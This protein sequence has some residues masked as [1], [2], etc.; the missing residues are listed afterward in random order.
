MGYRK[1][2][3]HATSGANAR[4]QIDGGC[5]RHSGGQ[6]GETSERGVAAIGGCEARCKV[7]SVGATTGLT[8]VVVVVV[9]VVVLV[10]PRRKRLAIEAEWS[11][12]HETVIVAMLR[13][14][15]GWQGGGVAEGAARRN[16]TVKDGA[17]SFVLG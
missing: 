16:S 2:A 15:V 12:A 1:G 8:A 14:R 11:S 9:V 5:R 6:Q 17:G 10:W 13:A 3:V 4:E 7:R